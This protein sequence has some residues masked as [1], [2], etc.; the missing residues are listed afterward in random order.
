MKKFLS[1]LVAISTITLLS[2]G[3]GEDDGDIT[4]TIPPK[5]DTQEQQPDTPTAPP[6]DPD[7]VY[8]IDASGTSG[9]ISEY[10]YGLNVSYD[11]SH[12]G[13]DYST[14]VRFGGNRTTGFNWENNASNA[15]SDWHHSSDD[16]LVGYSIKGSE[17]NAPGSVASTFIKNCLG[18]GQVPLFTI[19]IAYKVA[20]D[21]NGEVAEGDESRWVANLPC[22]GEEFSRTPDLGDGKVFQDECVDFLTSAAGGGGKI[23]YCLDNEPGIWHSTHPRIV[24]EHISCAEFIDRS[25]EFASAVKDVD[26][27]S[28]VFGFVAFGYS[29]YMSFA[30]APDWDKIKSESNYDWFIDYYLESMA[31]A[32]EEKGKTLVDVLDLH[33]YPEARGDERICSSTANSLKDKKARLQ[34]PRSLWDDT[35]KEDSW[36]TATSSNYFLPILPKILESIRKYSPT[37]KLAF[38]EYSYGGFDDITGAIALAEVLGIFGKYDIYAASHWGSPGSY[39][40]AAFKL[41]RDYDGN[42]S[43]FGEWRLESSMSGSWENTGVFA[44]ASTESADEIHVIV[45]NKNMD[46]PLEGKFVV[47]SNKNYTTATPYYVNGVSSSIRKVDPITIQDNTF[48]YNIPALSA[49]HIVISK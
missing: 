43:S 23:F 48:Q 37:T 6:S 11:F 31:K 26:P 29:S 39:G 25:I 16:F 20:A 42:K 49:V 18:S 19:P 27:L 1:L 13:E 9:K 38:T 28:T 3:G 4:P 17:R 34:A 21:M 46:E 45:T 14:M 8:T 30:G 33:W 22:K 47:S 24:P 41:Y 7:V 2:C 35:Y 36:I 5:D 12:S 44:S 15:G 40:D 10:I 32:S